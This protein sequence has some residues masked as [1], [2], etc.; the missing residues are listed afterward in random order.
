MSMGPFKDS[1]A[2]SWF[3]GPRV[4]VP[5]E[6]PLIGPDSQLLL[7]WYRGCY[8]QAIYT[9]NIYID[10]IVSRVLWYGVLTCNFNQFSTPSI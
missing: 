5:A 4:D 7:L 3:S 1:Q 6:P 10:P 9:G 8:G 2:P